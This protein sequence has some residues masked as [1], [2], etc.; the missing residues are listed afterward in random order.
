M[1]VSNLG[2]GRTRA[3]TTD[4]RGPTTR[5][6]RRTL[7][8]RFAVVCTSSH[9]IRTFAVVAKR[10]ITT[11]YLR[12][13][14][15]GISKL[16][17][18][19]TSRRRRRH[20]NTITVTPGPLAAIRPLEAVFTL[21]D[22]SPIP[23][24]HKPSTRPATCGTTVSCRFTRSTRLHTLSRGVVAHLASLA[25]G[26]EGALDAR[27]VVAD[28]EAGD[29]GA[30]GVLAAGDALVRGRALGCG[31]VGAVVVAD[32]LDALV[33]GGVAHDCVVGAGAVVGRR[34]F[35]TGSGVASGGAFDVGAMLVVAAGYAGAF[36]ALGGGY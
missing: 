34:A 8:I 20:A 31:S 13:W 5:T 18:S 26:V 28:G 17:D 29:G 32:A 30:V 25:V 35:D 19:L 9:R 4:Q 7:L 14:P 15:A 23:I 1:S 2:E 36:G 33:R 12:V 3:S 11:L 16:D 22:T 27:V 21:I 10:I 6:V 24:A